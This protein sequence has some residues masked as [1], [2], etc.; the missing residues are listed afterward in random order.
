MQNLIFFSFFCNLA[1]VYAALFLL[2]LGVEIRQHHLAL[3]C[4]N[5]FESVTKLKKEVVLQT[6]NVVVNNSEARHYTDSL[7]K[8]LDSRHGKT[9][10]WKWILSGTRQVFKHDQIK[11][12]D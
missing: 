8:L 7:L 12:T 3:V 10:Q 5:A 9:F 6:C 2:V 4:N 11:M 1:T